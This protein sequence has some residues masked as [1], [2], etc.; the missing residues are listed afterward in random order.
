[1]AS[2]LRIPSRQNKSRIIGLFRRYW[3][4][5]LVTNPLDPVPD[6]DGAARAAQPDPAQAQPPGSTRK[7]SLERIV[8]ISWRGWACGFSSGFMIAMVGVELSAKRALTTVSEVFGILG[9]IAG[10][11]ALWVT[12]RQGDVNTTAP[13]NAPAPATANSAASVRQ[14]FPGATHY[15]VLHTLSNALL[16]ALIITLLS[17]LFTFMTRIAFD[18]ICIILFVMAVVVVSIRYF[19][20]NHPSPWGD[21]GVWALWATSAVVGYFLATIIDIAIKSF[22]TS[23]GHSV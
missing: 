11:I 19:K 9:A 23:G 3:S 14:G 4:V 7:A 8:T 10:I 12:L 1:M 18:S 2:G 22:R 17:T 21:L 5:V 15:L 6:A 16:A 20:F 13:T